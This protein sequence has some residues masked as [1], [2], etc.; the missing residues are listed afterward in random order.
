MF[1][2]KLNTELERRGYK[3][4]QQKA[5]ACGLSYEYMRQ[6]LKGKPLAEERVFEIG[7]KLKLSEDVIASLVANKVLDQAKVPATK[8]ILSK[9]FCSEEL[10]VKKQ[11]HNRALINQQIQADNLMNLPTEEYK[12]P[13]YTTIKAG[14]GE[15]GVIEGETDGV[16]TINEEYKKMKVF[17]VK[18]SGDSMANEL[19]DGEIA[20][21]K[22]INGDPI[23]YK[24][25]SPL[26]YRIPGFPR[27]C[28]IRNVAREV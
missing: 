20:I 7:A 10:Q 8:E 12:I 27:P 11:P 28:T 14:N 26:K 3:T 19:Y 4:V 6:V 2:E 24:R 15:M 23:L 22:P 21:F 5:D 13:I 16:I 25:L 1:S 17:A 9:L 18:V